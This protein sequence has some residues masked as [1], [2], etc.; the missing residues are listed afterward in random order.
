M[1]DSRVARVCVL[2]CILRPLGRPKCLLQI[3]QR[4]LSPFSGVVFPVH[5]GSAARRSLIPFSTI[6]FQFSPLVVILKTTAGL[7]T[8]AMRANRFCPPLYNI[9]TVFCLACTTYIFSSLSDIPMRIESGRIYSV[10]CNFVTPR[11]LSITQDMKLHRGIVYLFFSLCRKMLFQYVFDSINWSNRAA[12]TLIPQPNGMPGTFCVTI[13]RR[14]YSMHTQLHLD[15][16]R[17]IP[18]SPMMRCP[19]NYK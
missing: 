19:R 12:Y 15:A 18:S 2:I 5:R 1:R 11:H 13:T 8:Y 16:L 10:Q 6:G 9:K 4:N 17:N 3:L 14:S 7:T